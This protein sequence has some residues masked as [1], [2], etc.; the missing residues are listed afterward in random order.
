MI[1]RN[2]RHILHVS[3]S[4]LLSFVV[5]SFWNS[6]SSWNSFWR[7]FL[8]LL[9]RPELLQLTNLDLNWLFVQMFNVSYKHLF[10]VF[11]IVLSW[12]SKQAVAHFKMHKIRAHKQS[13]GVMMKR[14]FLCFGSFYC[15]QKRDEKEERRNS[16]LLADASCDV[17]W[18]S[19]ERCVPWHN[20]SIFDVH[21]RRKFEINSEVLTWL[22]KRT[23][24][25]N[26]IFSLLTNFNGNQFELKIEI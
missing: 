6:F 21:H 25:Q 20:F 19:R 14:C 22:K 1:K 2:Y 3:L 26:E 18:S 13:M 16:F 11:L 17:L 7:S 24:A 12:V 15:C 10:F 5:W 8:S 9:S 23:K 4:L